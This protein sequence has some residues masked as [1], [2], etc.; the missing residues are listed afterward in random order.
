MEESIR[1]KLSVREIQEKDIPHI[2]DYWYTAK[3]EFLVL[4]G[5]EVGK[6]PSRPDFQAMLLTQLAAHYEHKKAY[7]I[8]WLYENKAIGHS[9]VN[10]LQYGV[11]ANIHLHL[12]DGAT[13]KK[14]L[15]TEFVKLTLPFYFQQLKLKKL[16]CEP[17]ALNP[18]PN[19]TLEKVGFDFVKEYT[20]VPGFINFEQAV[21]RWEMTQEKYHLL[22]GK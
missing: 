13:R 14:G 20:T 22:V 3:E 1:S 17:N 18:A 6:M 21:K 5:V 2:L 11:E 19:L 12:W 7:C 10:P 8:V 4:M 9:N 16:I 15:G